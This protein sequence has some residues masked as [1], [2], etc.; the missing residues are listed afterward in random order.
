MALSFAATIADMMTAT[1][2]ADKTQVISLITQGEGDLKTALTNAIKNL[3][4]PSG[5]LG[6]VFPMIE[7]S[8][9]TYADA[10]LA[11]YGPDV[12]FALLDNEIKAFTKNLG[13]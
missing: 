1:F 6:V 2:E 3:P 8:A 13:G 9:E 12:I 5:L 4:K 10:L 11:Q 7:K